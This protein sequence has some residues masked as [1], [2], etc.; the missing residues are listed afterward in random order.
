V[1]CALGV[2]IFAGGWQSP[3]ELDVSGIEPRLIGAL[4]FLAKAWG[5]AWLLAIARRAGFGENLG[6]S[7]SVLGCA[8]TVAL[9]ALWIWLEPPGAIELALGRALGGSLSIAALVTWVRALK[10]SSPPRLVAAASESVS[11]ASADPAAPG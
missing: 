2:A 9:T 1:L 4:L 11:G 6:A 8:L 7:G 10:L 5:F 3:P